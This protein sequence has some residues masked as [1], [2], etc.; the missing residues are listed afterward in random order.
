MPAEDTVPL[1]YFRCHRDCRL[2]YRLNAVSACS[3]KTT[4]EQTYEFSTN[5]YGMD[6]MKIEVIQFQFI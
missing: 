5:L 6:V 1:D 4:S 2:R 3:K